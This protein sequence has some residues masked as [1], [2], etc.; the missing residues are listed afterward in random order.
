[1]PHTARRLEA[2]G[3]QPLGNA[4]VL[5]VVL[6]VRYARV[7]QVWQRIQQPRALGLDGRELVLEPLGGIGRLRDL[8]LERGDLG[9]L[10]GLHERADLRRELLAHAQL[11]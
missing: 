4:L 10:A 1:V 11:V 2:G 9:L 6:A 7:E 3:R 5:R 8:L